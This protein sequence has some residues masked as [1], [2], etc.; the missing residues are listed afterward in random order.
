MR[1]LLCATSALFATTV[2]HAHHVRCAPYYRL[3]MLVLVASLLVYGVSPPPLWLAVVDRCAAHAAFGYIV[4]VDL[5]RRPE[6]AGFPAAVA[7]L[8]FA[9]GLWPA[10]ADALHALL[11]VVAVVGV[12]SF[13]RALYAE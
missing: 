6:L 5:P 4:C 7:G 8:W 9:E 12:H 3:F 11:H 13:L 1:T 10:E 2:V